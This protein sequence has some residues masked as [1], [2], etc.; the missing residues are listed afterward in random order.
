MP[1]RRMDEVADDAKKLA[2]LLREQKKAATELKKVE[3]GILETVAHGKITVTETVFAD[4]QIGLGAASSLV[5]AD[6]AGAEFYLS[7]NG[8]VT[9][10]PL[11]TETD[12]T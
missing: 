12:S 2:G 4:V 11:K 8:D 7:K 5:D 10:R 6:V 3:K 1:R 9:W